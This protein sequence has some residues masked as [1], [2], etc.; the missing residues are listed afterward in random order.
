MPVRPAPDPERRFGALLNELSFLLRQQ[1]ERRLRQQQIGLT[2]AQWRILRRVADREGRTQRELAEIMHL[3]PATVGRHIERL[4]ADGWIRRTRD[5]Q[6]ARV[7]RLAVQP[8][9]WR[10]LEQMQKVADRLRGEYFAGL[11]PGRSDGLVDDLL[12]IKNNL[13][14]LAPDP[15]LRPTHETTPDLA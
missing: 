6:D 8:K 9:A 11:A 3:K 14:S 12:H 7:W 2:R 1:F 4:E 15:K 13:L 5:P 10:T